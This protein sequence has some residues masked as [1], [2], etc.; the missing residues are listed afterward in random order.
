MNT[1]LHYS[2]SPLTEAVIDI[3]A[4]L[5]EGTGLEA[6]AQIQAGQETEYPKREDRVFVQGQFSSDPDQP[7]AVGVRTHIGY[8]FTHKDKLQLFQAR[9]DGFMFSRLAPYTGWENFCGEARRLWSI[10]RDIVRPQ[11]VTRVAVR[12]INRLDIP[13]PINDFKDYIRTVPE[14]SPDL[15]QGLS[16]Y[17]MQL[18][19]P[20]EDKPW[21]SVLNQ[22]LV[23]SP[24]PE[25][26][27]SIVL[28]IDL[29]QDHDV[30]SEEISLWELFTQLRARKN[31]IFKACITEKMERLIS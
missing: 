29:F 2:K 31:Q 18:H 1:E 17:F 20:Q 11:A 8:T 15:P 6:L 5:P 27:I 28:D 30:P 23:E 7:P 9:L 24:N 25:E 13:L 26:I 3:R 16:G 19:I 12:Y 22:V 21:M 14:V 4:T 10:Y